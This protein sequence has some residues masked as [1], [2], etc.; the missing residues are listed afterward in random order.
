[1][2]TWCRIQTE[3]GTIRIAAE[4]GAVTRVDFDRGEPVAPQGE[5]L[6]RAADQLREYAAGRRT[7]FDLPLRARGTE[8]QKRVWAAL[9]EIPYGQTRSYAE[10]AAAIGQAGA[11]RAVGSANHANPIWII[12]P[13]HRVVRAGGALGGYGGGLDNKRA[14]LDLERGGRH[15]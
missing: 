5:L 4:D 6:A 12:I 1:M 15:G 7:A 3:V 11:A 2:E 10:V 13:C 14:L 8:F 9:M